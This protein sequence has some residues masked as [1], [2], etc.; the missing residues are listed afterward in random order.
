MTKDEI[1]AAELQQPG[2]KTLF[3]QAQA[4]ADELH[5]WT[6][7]IP[8]KD[9]HPVEVRFPRATTR[10][11][12]KFATIRT[13]YDLNEQDVQEIRRKLSEQA[14]D[15]FIHEARLRL[16]G[17]EI[18]TTGAS[19]ITCEI[20]GEHGAGLYVRDGWWRTLLPEV[21]EILGYVPFGRKQ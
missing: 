19:R 8:G 2:W 18:L 1:I 10:C 15:Q 6:T 13:D 14:A 20:T 7:H 3:L 4:G 21:A 11:K 5:R 9:G 12:S 16:Q 17:M